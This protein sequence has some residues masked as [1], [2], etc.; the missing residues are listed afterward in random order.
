MSE[1]NI[2]NHDTV[3]LVEE[4]GQL[5]ISGS[6]FNEYRDK[7]FSLLSEH[8]TS[9]EAENFTQFLHDKSGLL[10]K[11]PVKFVFLLKG[12]F[13]EKNTF[14]VKSLAVLSQS[15]ILSKHHS[16]VVLL[17][18][19]HSMPKEP[20]LSES[21]F[22]SFVCDRY[23]VQSP[24]IF[25]QPSPAG[26]F[27]LFDVSRTPAL[28]TLYTYHPQVVL[29]KQSARVAPLP[30]ST[31]NDWLFLQ[32]TIFDYQKLKQLSSFDDWQVAD[33][34]RF[35]NGLMAIEHLVSQD[36]PDMQEAERL[37]SQLHDLQSHLADGF[38]V[39][40]SMAHA[41]GS[42]A[43]SY[44]NLIEKTGQ[45]FS[46]L[47]HFIDNQSQSTLSQSDFVYSALHEAIYSEV[48]WDDKQEENE[49][50]STGLV[51]LFA[52]W[53]RAGQQN[54][55]S[56]G[57][58]LKSIGKDALG[59][60]GQE[61]SNSMSLIQVFGFIQTKHYYELTGPLTAEEKL[62]LKLQ[63]V[64]LAELAEMPITWVIDTVSYFKSSTKM[65]TVR[66]LSSV[67]DV[68][69]KAF[70]VFGAFF[71]LAVD[72]Y[73]IYVSVKMLK[74]TNDDKMKA[75]VI[76]GLVMSVLGFVISLVMA[77]IIIGF[78]VASIAAS[79]TAAAVVTAATVVSGIAAGISGAMA[80][81]GPVGLA[82]ALV[83]MLVSGLY[84]AITTVKR[85][86]EKINMSASQKLH[87]GV[88]SFFMSII[89]I[90]DNFAT[91]DIENEYQ[92]IITKEMFAQM[93]LDFRETFLT[94]LVES[95][96]YGSEKLFRIAFTIDGL[97][98]KVKST[99]TKGLDKGYET[100][101]P[102]DNT[103]RNTVV[104]FDAFDFS[105]LVKNAN[106]K[107]VRDFQPDFPI[108]KMSH[109]LDGN[110]GLYSLKFEGW[111]VLT[112]AP[113]D[114][115]VP[116][117]SKTNPYEY[118]GNNHRLPTALGDF[119][120]DGQTDIVRFMD[121]GVHINTNLAGFFRTWE[122]AFRGFSPYR[123]R[124][125]NQS[126]HPR[127]VGDFNG[128]GFD[129]IIGFHES[130]VEALINR[131]LTSYPEDESNKHL[132]FGKQS[133]MKFPEPDVDSENQSSTTEPGKISGSFFTRAAG[134]SDQEN[135][136]RLIGDFNCDR[137][138]DIL[139][140][141][142]SDLTLALSTSE[143]NNFTPSFTLSDQSRFSGFQGVD[144]SSSTLL[145]GDFDGDGCTDL[146]GLQSREMI[147][148]MGTKLGAEEAAG[149]FSSKEYAS[150]F[151]SSYLRIVVDITNDKKDDILFINEDG[152][153]N[154]LVSQG[155]GSFKRV[156][157]KDGWFKYPQKTR[158]LG[159]EDK[160]WL[161]F[162]IKTKTASF[163]GRDHDN[164]V[165][166]H[167]SNGEI[168]RHVLGPDNFNSEDGV[169]AIE[170]GDGKDEAR[171]MRDRSNHFYIGEGIKIFKGGS[172]D[173]KFILNTE[174]VP[175]V[176]SQL[177]GGVEG[178]RPASFRQ[179]PV[180]EPI[181]NLTVYD[182]DRNQHDYFLAN[183]V[184]VKPQDV[185][186]GK[187]TGFDINL[188]QAAGF[189][190]Y[191]GSEQKIARLRNIEHATGN[192][193]TGD[194]IVGDEGFNVLDGLGSLFIEQPDIL[195]GG[196][197]ND[198]IVLNH[199]TKG[200]GGPGDDRYIFKK[201]AAATLVT[202]RD[203]EGDNSLMLAADLDEI[204][205][206]GPSEEPSDLVFYIDNGNDTKTYLILEKLLED[207]DA[208][209]HL[210][211]T[212]RD[213]FSFKFDGEK[214]V[215]KNFYFNMN[216][217][218]DASKDITYASDIASSK[219][220]IKVI[221]DIHYQKIQVVEMNEDLTEVV[222]VIRDVRVP[223]YAKL[224]ARASDFHDEIH[225]SLGN[226]IFTAG[227]GDDYMVGRGGEDYYVITA[228]DKPKLAGVTRINNF[229][230]S[231]SKQLAT[232]IVRIN[233]PQADIKL[234]KSDEDLII[235]DQSVKDK[236]LKDVIVERFFVSKSYRHLFLN[237]IHDITYELLINEQN[238]P[239]LGPGVIQGTSLSDDRP[240]EQ[241]YVKKLIGSSA[242]R[243]TLFGLDGDDLLQ[244]RSATEDV[245]GASIFDPANK[246][247]ILLGGNGS[248][249]LVD[250][251]GM[252]ILKGEEGNDLIIS[253][254]GDDVI[255]PGGGIDHVVF[256][257]GA[258]GLKTYL[259][260]AD[261]AGSL[262]KQ[263]SKKIM[264]PYDIEEAIYQR[265]GDD[266]QMIMM[267]DY[268]VLSSMDSTEED[269]KKALKDALVI[270][271]KDFY[272]SMYFRR[273]RL[274][275]YDVE[276]LKTT[277][278]I[279]RNLPA[280]LTTLKQRDGKTLL[281]AYS[282]KSKL[283]QK[284][285][286]RAPIEQSDKLEIT[287]NVS[288]PIFIDKLSGK[289]HLSMNLSAERQFSLLVQAASSLP[290]QKVPS[291]FDAP[292]RVA[293]QAWQYLSQG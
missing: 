241:G 245:A 236:K 212:T 221:Q 76:F 99:Y 67:S 128:D 150:F 159:K 253:S 57:G 199:N 218:Y 53:M 132:G 166:V 197:G 238:Q 210:S 127:M 188:H 17:N 34:M 170:L 3:V 35:T 28:D 137:R 259:V 203:T 230:P 290:E 69:S 50:Q 86:E 58:W 7:N 267:D 14:L 169:L 264:V 192:A 277:S 42:T 254:L 39:G 38:F 152:S 105:T 246:G 72:S 155:D 82:V 291:Y 147:V 160:D 122:H 75:G 220:T 23:G 198:L 54:F 5:V 104:N 179:P 243:T 293:D 134:F 80:M 239:I 194:H 8:L 40:Q 97:E 66:F 37:I 41:E 156:K 87:L 232:D 292:L 95:L 145:T 70:F 148:A 227:K 216:L 270:H 283:N 110:K 26:P 18:A 280:S 261:L 226:D 113:S 164:A 119:N 269:F 114:G 79:V 106:K 131:R 56:A 262:A 191:Q 161:Y 248:D 249:V 167:F 13:S 74:S 247:D 173:D 27:S 282:E 172:M 274:A 121:R 223:G 88:R 168:V 116:A 234:V 130:Y 141:K 181:E 11:S 233:L 63:M 33:F 21:N 183:V 275:S 45:L 15:G 61:M 271:V 47:S 268:S 288:D 100:Y 90:Q 102:K 111:R 255:E 77:S 143:L 279:D 278:G 242:S 44:K 225:G 20:P 24:V 180:F 195:E 289:D 202:V 252:D 205:G 12:S 157:S 117:G 124:Y 91:A 163:I 265:V 85:Y 184:Y 9:S 215:S 68:I 224:K 217:S 36:A 78:V 98:L 175:D 129:D 187:V 228:L 16:Q 84:G 64:Q 177:D 165:Y 229:D 30:S 138:D 43:G 101:E 189:V 83:M 153:F 171:G 60:L 123:G 94:R 109:S 208:I 22:F 266:L 89:P 25:E 193:N 286:K 178:V 176:P 204:L 200:Y 256:M 235:R 185:Q 81:V 260:P 108:G 4:S 10:Q 287:N 92:K 6:Q 103:P 201:P 244:A 71:G 273:F 107:D 196:G 154:G 51:P 207:E 93:Y 151:K 135:S 250:S 219:G 19:S 115:T 284:S 251:V 31:L 222:R 285:A 211:F 272:K 281:D 29:P 55:S 126:K 214:G 162:N 144:W 158:T 258:K 136:P 257:P 149:G 142:D 209:N 133:I 52:R 213:G 32:E 231:A 48:V 182:K 96:A 276:S 62:D 1:K 186:A 237:D 59:R 263:R 140:A 240:D 125:E 49:D 190:K 2:E 146:A 65:M 46:D 118:T 174:K 206:L 120:G 73:S 139:G 112:R